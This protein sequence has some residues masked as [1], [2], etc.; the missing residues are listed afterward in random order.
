MFSFLTVAPVTSGLV[1]L[2]LATSKDSSATKVL[3]VC[4]SPAC[5]DDG[6]ISTLDRIIALAPPCT[7][8][9]KGR[10][11]SL[12]GSGPIVEICDKIDDVQ[13][14]KRKRVK[15]KAVIQLLDEFME[16][17]SDFT[18]SLRDRLL[19]GYDFYIE[20]NTAYESKQYQLAIELYE[21]AIQNGRKPAIALQEARENYAAEEK[22]QSTES[23]P[24]SIDWIVTTFRKS[25]RCKLE[26]GDI[27]GARRDAFA[28]TVFSKNNDAAS[29]ECLAD[30]CKESG[31]TIG[32]YQAIK[33]AIE[34]YG[35]VEEKHSRPMPGIDAV[36]RAESARMRN[37]ARERQREMGFRLAKL[38][39]LLNT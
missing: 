30:V 19:Q 11:T 31:D 20:A 37:D 29:H 17:D 12:C 23:Y 4:T 34:Q 36:R 8:V 26:L 15:D 27:D 22:I 38:E 39:K 28:S 24:A 33:A 13:S 6:A 10:C 7:N 9:V 1:S 32:E 21:Q 3:R 2:L 35:K 16:G 14:V 25:C 5:K 18:P